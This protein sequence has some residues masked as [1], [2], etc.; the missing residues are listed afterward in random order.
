VL[1]NLGERREGGVDRRPKT[2]YVKCMGFEK[3]TEIR[4]AGREDAETKDNLREFCDI[5]S[6]R[7][8]ASGDISYGGVKAKFD[9]WKEGRMGSRSGEG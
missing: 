6:P 4:R 3:V 5:S 7:V 9:P 2:R 8:K 1:R